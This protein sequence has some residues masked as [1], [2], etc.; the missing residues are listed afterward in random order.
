MQQLN[1]RELQ[2]A[3]VQSKGVSP[4]CEKRQ[5]DGLQ[6]IKNLNPLEKQVFLVAM[7]DGVKKITKYL[8][9]PRKDGAKYKGAISILLDEQGN[10]SDVRFK[11]RSGNDELDAA[12]YNAIMSAGYL[13][14]PSDPEAQK[15]KTIFPLTLS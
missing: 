7:N 13:D 1:D 4:K 5:V 6:A 2:R 3:I 9:A 11:Q 10:I 8:D 12:F 14:L 15:T